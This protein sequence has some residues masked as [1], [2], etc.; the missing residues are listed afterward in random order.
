MAQ[1][2]TSY[3]RKIL[4]NIFYAFVPPHSVVHLFSKVKLNSNISLK[5]T[6]KPFGFSGVRKGGRAVKKRLK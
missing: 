1:V 5:P 6:L 3:V 4:Q 2:V